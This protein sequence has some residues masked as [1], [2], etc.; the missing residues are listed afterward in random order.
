[1][2][3]LKTATT[4][5]LQEDAVRMLNA[6]A[7]KYELKDAGKALRCLIEYAAQEGDWDSI[8]GQVRCMRCGGRPGWVEKAPR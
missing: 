8:F 3:G 7:E 2:A 1:M 5:E 4:F 6:A